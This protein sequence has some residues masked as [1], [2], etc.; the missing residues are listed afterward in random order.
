MSGISTGIGLISGIN[1]ASLIDQLI[2]IERRPIN[3]LQSRV[4]AIEI[5]RT[6]FLRLSAQLLSLKNSVA[7][8]G[9]TSFFNRFTSTSTDESVLT[10]TAGDDAVPGSITFRVRS[11]VSTHSV[12]SHG[13]ADRDTTPSR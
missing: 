2:A 7:N 6:A 4:S 13:F 10:A 9:R 1:I 3:T 5:Q 8:F 12:I 11:L